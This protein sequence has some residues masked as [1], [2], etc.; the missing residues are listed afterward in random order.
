MWLE[1]DFSLV[2][3]DVLRRRLDV[4]HNTIGRNRD[5]DSK[6][7]EEQE[8]LSMVKESLY[9]FPEEPVKNIWGWYS[10]IEGVGMM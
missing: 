9:S 7:E 8:N 6:S 5:D 3:F 4:C 1:G 2:V 10:K